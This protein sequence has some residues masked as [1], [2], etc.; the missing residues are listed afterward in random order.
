MLNK[1]TRKEKINLL[2]AIKSGVISI[3]DIGTPAVYVFSPIF[4]KEGYFMMNG[5]E[6]NNLEYDAFCSLVEQKN[7]RL[8]AFIGMFPNLKEDLIITIVYSKGKTIL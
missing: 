6:Y 5:N 2:T 4:G 8:R 1:F 7:Q 3:S